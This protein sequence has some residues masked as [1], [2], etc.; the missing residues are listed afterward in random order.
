[1]YKKEWPFNSTDN[2]EEK[3]SFLRSL[4]ESKFIRNKNDLSAIDYKAGSQ[5]LYLYVIALYA[6][7]QE[8]ETEM[9]AR[10]YAAAA[11][12]FNNFDHYRVSLNDLYNLC[13]LFFGDTKY[14]SVDLEVQYKKDITVGKYMIRYL[15]SIAQ[16]KAKSTD[17]YVLATKLE[18]MLNMD[19]SIF[20][21]IRREITN[22]D[23]LRPAD[24][25][26]VFKKLYKYIRAISM[27]ADLLPFIKKHTGPVDSLTKTQKTA[28]GVAAIVGGFAAGYK[29][30]RRK[31]NERTFRKYNQ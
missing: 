20:K 9:S 5:L 18:N 6:L 14:G 1:M 12:A 30:T 8:S 28:L 23:K 11:A 7:A 26:S 13:H 3:F 16:D 4:D 24:K 27:R 29:L 25:S 22:W 15:R 17:L 31:K 19:N 10:Q 2:E 21:N